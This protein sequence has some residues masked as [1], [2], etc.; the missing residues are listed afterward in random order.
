MTAIL[1]FGSWDVSSCPVVPTVRCSQE[2]RHD[3]IEHGDFLHAIQRMRRDLEARATSNKQRLPGVLRERRSG[4]GP[5]FLMADRKSRRKG[6][7]QKVGKK[8]IS[9]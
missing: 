6:I 8:Q 7:G 4:T 1:L 2:S 9:H 5:S 3:R